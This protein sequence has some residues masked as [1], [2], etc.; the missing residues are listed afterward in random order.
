MN[1]LN[2]CTCKFFAEKQHP[3]FQG[4]PLSEKGEKIVRTQSKMYTD[5]ILFPLAK[6]HGPQ[7]LDNRTFC[8]LFH[9]PVP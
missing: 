8:L 7:P 6:V 4:Y 2:L 3:F 1:T 5:S 9:Q